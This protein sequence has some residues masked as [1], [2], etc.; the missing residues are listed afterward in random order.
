MTIIVT[1]EARQELRAIKLY[2]S[3]VAGARETACNLIS[4]IE[5]Q[6]DDLEYFPKRHKVWQESDFRFFTVRNYM[7]FYRIDE[8][9]EKIIVERIIYS[10]RNIETLL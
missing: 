7:V 4:E 3:N 10:R 6:I 5:T 1:D 9:S 2:I 8:A